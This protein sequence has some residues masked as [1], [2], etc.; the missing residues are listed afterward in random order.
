MSPQKLTL[1]IQQT[2]FDSNEANAM[3]KIKTRLKSLKKKYKVIGPERGAH[4]GRDSIFLSA[5]L[6]RFER[7]T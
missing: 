6:A 5:L 3:P 4:G 7:C 2:L 1:N